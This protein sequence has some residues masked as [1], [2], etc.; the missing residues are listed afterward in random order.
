MPKINHQLLVWARKEASLSTDEACSALKLN[1]DL[2]T[3]SR[4]RTFRFQC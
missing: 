1:D 2:E 4:Y 3:A